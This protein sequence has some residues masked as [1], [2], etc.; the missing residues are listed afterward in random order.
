MALTRR[1]CDRCV[2]TW[3]KWLFGNRLEE[4]RR[5]EESI[6]RISPFEPY[7]PFIGLI[8]IDIACLHCTL[9]VAEEVEMVDRRL[10]ANWEGHTRQAQKFKA[11]CQEETSQATANVGVSK[12]GG[13]LAAHSPCHFEVIAIDH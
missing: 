9:E 13:D 10:E 7:S 11:G 5:K 3:T 12:T 8:G 6:D 4:D 1:G 2:R